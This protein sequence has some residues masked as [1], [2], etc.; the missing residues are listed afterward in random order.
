MVEPCQHY[1]ATIVDG[2][3]KQGARS[4]IEYSGSLAG[5]GAT[6][7]IPAV[8]NTSARFFMIIPPVARGRQIRLLRQKR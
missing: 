1:I 8:Q 5:A 6:R 3:P 4:A 7:V 2:E